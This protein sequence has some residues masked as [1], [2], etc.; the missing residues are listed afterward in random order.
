MCSGGRIIEHLEEGLNIPENDVLFVGY[1]SKGTPGRDIQKYG[2]RPNSYVYLNGSKVVINAEIHNLSGYSAHADQKGL[3]D[4][5]ESM[6]EKPKKIKL[7]HG[8]QHAR[9]ELAVVLEDK[10]YNVKYE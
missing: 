1:Q 8:G 10:G 3:V 9:Q 2:N 6:P 7:V 5:V 4:W